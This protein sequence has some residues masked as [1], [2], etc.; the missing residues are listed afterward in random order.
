MSLSKLITS[1]YLSIGTN[2]QRRPWSPQCSKLAWLEYPRKVQIRHGFTPVYF[3]NR[4]R[5]NQRAMEPDDLQL[6]TTRSGLKYFVWGTRAMKNQSTFKVNPSSAP[7][8][9]HSV[10]HGWNFRDW[11]TFL[12]SK[13]F[14][15][16]VGK[17]E[18]KAPR[19]PVFDLRSVSR[20]I[21]D[22]KIWYGEAVVRRQIVKI[23]S[24]DVM[25][26]VPQR[27]SRRSLAFY[28][29]KVP[30]FTYSS[31]REYK[32]AVYFSF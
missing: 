1:F 29:G 15:R 7:D 26:R 30:S 4:G 32:P 20:V 25:S 21:R 28:Y 10:F 17:Y 24:G 16:Y 12:S 6:K 2:F 22:F 13:A 31:L 3:G 5:E 19:F 11:N 23:T 18:P 9:T 14:E 8:F 27:L